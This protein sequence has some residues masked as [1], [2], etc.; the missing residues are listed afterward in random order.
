MSESPTPVREPSGDGAPPVRAVLWHRTLPRAREDDELDAIAAWA[1][2]VSARFR[3]AGGEIVGQ[4]SGAVVAS[5]DPTEIADAL[6]VALDLLEE[7]D[8]LALPIAFGAAVGAVTRRDGAVVG[9]ALDLAAVLA[10][11]AHPGELVLDASARDRVSE[12]FLFAR[13]VGTGTGGVRGHAID[14]SHPRKDSCAAGILS[15]GAPPIAPATAGLL[16]ELIAAIRDRPRPF[17]VLRGPVG[18]GAVEVL[19]A[20]ADLAEARDVLA[21]GSS[22]GGVVPLGSLRLALARWLGAPEMLRERCSAAHAETLQRVM[23]GALVDEDS[24]VEALVDLLGGS[25]RPWIFLTP[26]ALVD[27]ATLDVC[28]GLRR[29]MDVALFARF[30]VEARLPPALDPEAIV[31][32]VLPPL[33]TSDARTIA[34]SILGSDTSA[35]VARRV[36]VLGGETPLGVIE[37]ARTFIAAGDLVLESLERRGQPSPAGARF[38]WR[39]TPRGGA[40]ALALDTLVGERLAML[41]DVSRQVLEAICVAPEGSDRAL[42]LAIC[43]RDGVNDRAL[44]RALERLVREAWLAPSGAA[45]PFGS[46]AGGADRPQPSSSFVRRFVAQ[47][48]PPARSAELHRFTADALAASG[49]DDPTRGSARA[50]LGFYAIEG[51]REPEGAALLV[52]V[53]KA[54]LALGYRRAAARLASTAARAGGRVTAEADALSR[55]AATLPPPPSVEE[56][57]LIPSSEISL[58]TLAG[59]EID[60]HS[61]MLRTVEMRLPDEADDL[62]PPELPP[63]PDLAPSEGPRTGRVPRAPLDTGELLRSREQADAAARE[64]R[65]QADAAAREQR[66]QT[67]PAP[68]PDEGSAENFVALA[69]DAVRRRDLAALDRLAERAVA[70]G[71]DMGAIAR[72]RALADLL[73]G[74]V[75]G[76]TRGLAKAR[77]HGRGADAKTALAEA[78]VQLG[79]GDPSRALRFALRALAVSRRAAEPRGE[80]AALRT[81]AAC[82]RAL[83]M[84]DTSRSIE[85]RVG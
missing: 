57:E 63:L 13:Q 66:V 49:A 5:F 15:L 62:A 4:I 58:D 17:I 42:C 10:A 18:A 69:A 27:A 25:S 47:S 38:V 36:A 45:W 23:R 65:E 33:R 39:G 80:A 9:R 40:S 71:S 85:A 64:Q 41:D 82:Y 35:E 24:A 81:L 1:R 31:E 44:G 46:A 28:L 59:A 52:D 56:D 29:R 11:R 76:A 83:G 12:L 61:A 2:S 48:M 67:D 3:A 60:A 7:A 16:P 22:P 32:V 34:Q 77:D 54:A 68:A 20:L 55:A 21:I 26:L 79:K 8:E 75:G 6:E 70:A 51:G 84:L 43:E 73:K 30:P 50:E 19:R 72:F 53:G 37:V 78:L 74:D 14:R